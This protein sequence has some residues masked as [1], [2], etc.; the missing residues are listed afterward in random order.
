MM[1][2]TNV[3]KKLFIAEGVACDHSLFLAS[4]DDRPGEVLME[5]PRD[6]NE[7]RSGESITD[8][9]NRGDLKIAWRYQNMPKVPSA[10][11]Q[12][13]FGHYFDLSETISEGKINSLSYT[14]FS[15][16]FCSNFPM[17]CLS[18]CIHV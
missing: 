6:A 5:I 3:L 10:I 17:C 16:S 15:P 8:V 7:D 14:C 1:L 4:A 9:D 13:Q 12:T 18:F 11:P 2:Y